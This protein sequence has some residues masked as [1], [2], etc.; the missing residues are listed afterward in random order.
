MSAR[1]A[2]TRA[3]LPGFLH[4]LALVAALALTAAALAAGLPGPA[5]VAAVVVLAALA[6]ARAERRRPHAAA[7]LRDQGD[8]DADRLH[9]VV[10]LACAEGGARLVGLALAERASL[11]L[12]AAAL[13]A[14][15]LP[16]QVV[17]GLLATDLAGYLGHRLLHARGWPWRC[18]AVHHA[19]RRLYWLNAARNHPVDVLVS[20]LATALPLRLAGLSPAAVALLTA[21]GSV[22][23]LLQHANL[24]FTPGRWDRWLATAPMHRMHHLP[25]AASAPGGRAP[26]YNLGRVL[27]LWD[28]LF[29]TFVP[30]RAVAADAVGPGADPAGDPAH[31]PDDWWGQLR[32]P[33]RSR[34]GRRSPTI[35]V[36]DTAKNPR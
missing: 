12:P 8:R 26:A 30:A 34:R 23:L 9:L 15:T 10:T 4:P 6:I 28:R 22:H 24:A 7:W 2:A 14:A 31:V 35:L 3:A 25:P 33:F 20:T 1:A 13:P 19:A 29:G 21:L 5:A 18:H 17:L 32:A 27:S 36:T 16:L 11:A